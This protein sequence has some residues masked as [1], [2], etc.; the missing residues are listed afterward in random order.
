MDGLPKPVQRP[1]P[2]ILI[3][4]GGRRLL[5]LAARE[6]DIVG[7]APRIL[8]TTG[9]GDPRSIT[10]AA[11]E[12]KLGWVRAAAGDRFENLE[13]NIYPS[14]SPIVVTDHARTR[15]DDLAA[16]IRERTGF[17]IGA[18][19]LLESPHIFIGSIDGLARKLVELR[20][21]LGTSNVMLGELGELDPLVEPLAGT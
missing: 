5:E 11:A 10:L 8:S 17:E 6:A 18:D 14:M 1:H 7:L 3:G 19:D 12:E 16:Q 13:L 15:A 20:E 4:G 9:R 2:P 21:R